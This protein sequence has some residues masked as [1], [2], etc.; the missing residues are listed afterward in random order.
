MLARDDGIHGRAGKDQTMSPARRMNTT[1]Q[2][3]LATLSRHLTTSHDPSYKT[4][5]ASILPHSAPGRSLKFTDE[6]WTLRCKLACAYR[7]A[8][9]LGWDQVIFNHITARIPN[10][11]HDS[12][13]PYFLINPLGL[14]FDEVTACSLLKVTTE[15]KIKDNGTNAGGLFRQGFVIHSAIHAVRHDAVCVWHCHHEN[16]AA[17]CMTKTGLL[18]LS[19]EAIGVLPQVAYHP[20]EGTANDM[21]EIPRLQQNIGH[22]KKILLLDNHGPLTLGTTIDEAFALMFNVCR[23]SSYQ[24]KAMAAVGGNL[25]RLYLPDETKLAAMYERGR[26]NTRMKEAEKGGGS[27]G[28]GGD[29]DYEEGAGANPSDELM[30]RALCRVVE[31]KYGAEKIYDIERAYVD[32]EGRRSSGVLEKETTTRRRRRRVEA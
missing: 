13:G 12:D 1:T 27:G 25:D 32:V 4:S 23:A 6:E 11:E 8:N 31:D 9:S 18:P 28:G 16:T 30:F 5:W 7:V 20:F 2:R 14:R 10:S 24:Q 22:H 26:N 19:Q 15:G 29:G 3:R 17:V 21:S